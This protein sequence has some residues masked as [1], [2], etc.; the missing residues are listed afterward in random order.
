MSAAADMAQE[1]PSPY[2]E[3]T[4][5][6]EVRVPADPSQLAV[7]RAVA[8]DLAMRADFDVDSIADIRLAVDEACSSLV[9]LASRTA[10][11][12]CRYHADSAGLT[13]TSEVLSGEHSGPRKDTFSWRVLSALTDSVSTSVE[14][15]DGSVDSHLVR[16][17]LT[18]GRMAHE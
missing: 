18:K 16:I 15:V 10:S 1:A 7:M 14:A 3:G 13:V 17:E 8:G 9:R 5:V 6:V 2:G 12:V 11:L 4:N